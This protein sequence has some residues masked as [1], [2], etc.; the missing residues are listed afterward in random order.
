[1]KAII[2]IIVLLLIGWGIWS[3]VKKDVPADNQAAQ[4]GSALNE[5][6]SSSNGASVDVNAGASTDENGVPY[7]DKG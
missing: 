3:F 5:N 2:W 7:D 1:M 4:A 6:G